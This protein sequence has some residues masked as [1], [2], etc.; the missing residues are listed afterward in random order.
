[1]SSNLPMTM[2][3]LILLAGTPRSAIEPRREMDAEGE[4]HRGQRRRR[5][6]IRLSYYLSAKDSRIYQACTWAT[7]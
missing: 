7:R 5:M 3:V 2:R 4:V 6:P 1:M